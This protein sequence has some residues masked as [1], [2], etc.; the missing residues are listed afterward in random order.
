MDKHTAKQYSPLTMAF[1]GDAV[2]SELVRSMLVLRANMSVKKLH[3]ASVR[4]VRAS[5]QAAA[6]DLI[7]PVLSEDEADILRRGRNAPSGSHV[8]KN[9]DRDEYSKA[10]AVETLFG[11][12]KLSGEDSRINELF[13]MIVNKV[14][15]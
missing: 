11:Y 1:L 8:P 2:Y 14:E 13:E 12:L 6:Y 10:T 4:Y 15:I 7:L 3:A 5:Y 9:S